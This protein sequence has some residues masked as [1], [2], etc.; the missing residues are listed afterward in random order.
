VKIEEFENSGTK[1]MDTYSKSKRGCCRLI[2]IHATFYVD[3]AKEETFLKEIQP[4][5]ESSRAESGC[6]DY[7]LQKDVEKKNVYL[8]VEVWQDS[9]AVDEHNKSEH[10]TSFVAKADQFLTAPLD[11]QLFEG[12]TLH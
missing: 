10:F 1:N 7:R 5:M 8:M 3:P 4:L 6:I 12:H 2:I 11:V 9:Q